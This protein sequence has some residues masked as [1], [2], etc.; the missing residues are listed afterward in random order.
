MNAIT[1][2][3]VYGWITRLAEGICLNRN[4]EAKLKVTGGD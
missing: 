3:D 4:T 1:L 2:E